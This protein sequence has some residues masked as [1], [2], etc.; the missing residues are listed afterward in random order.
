VARKRPALT[1]S[2]SGRALSLVAVEETETEAEG[3]EVEVERQKTVAPQREQKERRRSGADSYSLRGLLAGRGKVSGWWGVFSWGRVELGSGTGVGFG[4]AQSEMR[5]FCRGMKAQ[6]WI[7][8]P[9]VRRHVRQAQVPARYLSAR[10][11]AG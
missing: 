4:R 7:S 3:V 8:K 11:W 5:M 2:R 10:C 6:V 1:S 9:E